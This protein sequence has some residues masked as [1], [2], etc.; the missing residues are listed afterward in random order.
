MRSLILIIALLGCWSIAALGQK[1]KT[2]SSELLKQ[3]LA[4]PAP[5]PRVR[6]ADEAKQILTPKAHPP[7]D[8]APIEDLQQY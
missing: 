1:P 5:M 4:V 3:L 2:D 6:D 8:D 7:P